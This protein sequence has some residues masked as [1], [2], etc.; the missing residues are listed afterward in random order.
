METLG[1]LRAPAGFS[2]R[3]LAKFMSVIE[4]CGPAGN[5]WLQGSSPTRNQRLVAS[6]VSSTV[7]GQ[8]G[9]SPFN[10]K[11]MERMRGRKEDK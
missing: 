2:L 10:I 4:P 8:G 11:R 7:E 3:Y 1:L 6:R 9:N 5:D